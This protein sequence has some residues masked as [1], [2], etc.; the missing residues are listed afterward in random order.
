MSKAKVFVGM[1]RVARV[2]K[3]YTDRCRWEWRDVLYT[4]KV[5]EPVMGKM[6]RDVDERFRCCRHSQPHT[7]EG[8][9]ELGILV[10]L[11]ALEHD[12]L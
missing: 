1:M 2:H 5:M 12:R 11:L 10:G 8:E 6:Y 9:N 7:G 3:T 4:E